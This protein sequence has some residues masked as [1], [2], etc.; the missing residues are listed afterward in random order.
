MNN[1]QI[2]S[3]VCNYL[4]L[5]FKQNDKN[6]LHIEN[7][8]IDSFYKN[9]CGITSYGCGQN[10]LYCVT[11]GGKNYIY[12]NLYEMLLWYY[13]YATKHKH[14]KKYFKMK[15]HKI[16]IKPYF[17]ALPEYYL[18]IDPKKG[19]NIVKEAMEQLILIEGGI[20]HDFNPG[21]LNDIYTIKYHL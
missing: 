5:D 16:H 1:K 13:Y 9:E 19:L 4:N 17:S 18:N 10:R 3:D 7:F 2:F 12:H 11:K 21:V 6:H 8:P 14:I 20:P 15:G